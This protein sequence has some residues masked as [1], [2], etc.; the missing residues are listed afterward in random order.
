MDEMRTFLLGVIVS[1]TYSPSMLLKF[2]SR[3]LPDGTHNHYI[4][5]RRPAPKDYLNRFPHDYVFDGETEL[6]DEAIEREEWE[7]LVPAD[8]ALQILDL[9]GDA[10]ELPFTG[11]VMGG[12]GG[13]LYGVFFDKSAADGLH[14]WL[15]EPPEEWA[16]LGRAVDELIYWA[17]TAYVK[18]FNRFFDLL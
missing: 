4:T 9:F 6:S 1:P 8:R 18:K 3:A 17:K 5:C 2:E 12:P 15:I 16:P 14:C 10:R 7:G 13:N 11:E